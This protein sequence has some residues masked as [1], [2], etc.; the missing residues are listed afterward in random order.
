MMHLAR[1]EL[2]GP[3]KYP[4]E[5]GPE[6]RPWF[7]I[8]AFV[9]LLVIALGCRLLAGP[10]NAVMGLDL[11]DWQQ[12]SQDLLTGD[13]RHFY[14]ASGSDY[15]PG[16]LYVLWA[17]GHVQQAFNHAP[18]AIQGWLPSTTVLFKLPAMIA[19]L[20]TV[21]VI[22]WA[23]RRWVPSAAAYLAALS[24]AVN[25]GVI[26][27][28]TVWGQ[29]D[30]VPALFMLLALVLL[31]ESRPGPSG[32][33]LALSAL[34]KPT[35][36][37]LLPLCL[38]ILC[39]RRRWRDLLSFGAAGLATSIVVFFPFIPYDT[40]PLTFAHHVFTVT[41]GRYPFLTINAFNL[42]VLVQGK[43]GFLSDANLVLGVRYA[44][45]G[46][47]M[48]ATLS[49]VAG[50]LLALRL[51]RFPGEEVKTVLAVGSILMLGFFVLLTRMHERHLL[52]ALPLLALTSAVWPRYWLPYCWLSAAYFLNVWYA[53]YVL[54][55][56]FDH[57]LGPAA[58]LGISLLNVAMLGLLVAFLWPASRHPARGSA[59]VRRLAARWSS[60][61]GT[62]SAG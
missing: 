6:R 46:W 27:N 57:E 33:S 31:L 24:Y 22:Y 38:F 39:Y 14:A 25:P 3:T 12:W 28:S 17:L 32:V 10:A 16:Y 18:D 61:A 9:S 30:S 51:R 21:A 5:V 8:G 26:Y 47:A 40:N 41:S 15:L 36:V 2:G 23:G 62:G 54:L 44:A 48:L 11:V 43:L 42:W 56:P 59:L 52:P 58:I 13:W 7:E 49:V 53:Y 4:V 1:R 20:V 55:P 50:S 60:R 45:L 37:V 34:C 35:A 19:D 29:V